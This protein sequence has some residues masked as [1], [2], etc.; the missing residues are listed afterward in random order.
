M[1]TLRIPGSVV[2]VA[3]FVTGIGRAQEEP[4]CVENSP[5]RRGEI[6][7]SIVEKKTLPTTLR[8]PAFWHI[9]Q[10]DSAYRAQAGV[11]PSS[12]A[13]EAHAA[14]WLMSVGPES[15]DH[16][17]GKHVAQVNLS[18]LPKAEGYSMLVISPYIPAG[19]TSR[20]HFHSGVEAFYTVDG[21]QCLETK[22][23]AFPMTK[24]DTLVVPAGITMRLVATGTK[25]RRAFAVIVYDSSKP[26][27]T[28]L[29]META[30]QLVSCTR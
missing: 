13:F 6:G 10:F 24:G 3:L 28:R 1:R 2:F 20:V 27:V 30:S 21:E 11:G 15:N 23:K 17:G 26:P 8:E 4:V 7:C 22:D 14:W 19:M 16:R 12:I 25:P 29:P 9:D 18:P 5:E